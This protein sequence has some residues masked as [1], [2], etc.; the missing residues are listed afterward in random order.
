MS[1]VTHIPAFGLFGEAEGFPDVLS[2]ETLSARAAL[3]DW[4]ITP[5]RH[6]ALAQLVVVKSGNVDAKIDDLS[7]KLQDN[8]FVFL[9]A[10]CVH[11]FTFEPNCNGFVISIPSE[12][13]TAAS[14]QGGDLAKHL[15]QPFIGELDD[16]LANGCALIAKGAAE[17]SDFRTAKLI[18]LAHFMLLTLAELRS[19]QGAGAVSAP[20]AK[21]Q[22]LDHLID[23]HAEHNWTASRYAQ[24]LAMS[25][26]HLSRLCRQAAGYGATAYIERR[27]MNEAS[28]LL[29]FTKLPIAEIGLR[30]GF[31]DPSYFSKRFKTQV[32]Q[33]PSEYRARF[34][35]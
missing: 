21:L 31:E 9:P 28:R 34:T 1:D 18:S 15:S 10:M 23:Q 29:A 13:V 16:D 25:T 14:P 33:T 12:I 32:S 35:I 17:Q 8:Q 6:H 30:L 20:S 2:Y 19:K 26:G 22:E 24:A 7:T 11:A 5:H 3:N 27:L 4:R